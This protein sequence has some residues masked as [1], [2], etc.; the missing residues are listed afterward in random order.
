VGP[1][2]RRG[3]GSQLCPGCYG[4]CPSRAPSETRRPKGSAAPCF[5]CGDELEQPGADG[6]TTTARGVRC[7]SVQT[8]CIRVCCG[9]EFAYNSFH[10]AHWASIPNG[11]V[12]MLR[13]PGLLFE[14]MTL[15][16]C[17]HGCMNC[18]VSATAAFPYPK[19]GDVVRYPGKW[20]DDYGIGQIRFLQKIG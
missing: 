10:C 15:Y 14:C 1:G 7:S 2:T 13:A 18:R 12:S 9:D 11:S 17:M 8:M 19:L 3:T 4:F 5:H 20:E 6:A 16:L